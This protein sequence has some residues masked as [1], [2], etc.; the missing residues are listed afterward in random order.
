MRCVLTSARPPHRMA[1]STSPEGA[2]RT[3]LH[4]GKLVFKHA[5][6]RAELASVVFCDSMVRTTE[7]STES[8]EDAEDRAGRPWSA[9]SCLV[10]KK[11][12]TRSE[13]H[14]V[15]RERGTHHSAGVGRGQSG[16]GVS[17]AKPFSVG[18]VTPSVAN[19]HGDGGPLSCAADP[20]APA[21]PDPDASLPA[22]PG[23][24]KCA[25]CHASRNSSF[26]SL[27]ILL[28]ARRSSRPMARIWLGI[29]ASSANS[30]TL[31]LC[32]VLD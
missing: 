7:S 5:N 1:S 26:G 3:W 8:R 29:L 9:S 23:S 4:S 31:S 21:V 15:G 13:E 10:A 20:P 25:A 18:T 24:P 14:R 12:R 17:S 32:I 19:W 30:V 16:K 2:S 28:V 22:A 11:L 27:V 6:A